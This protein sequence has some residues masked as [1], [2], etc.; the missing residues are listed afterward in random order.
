MTLD[1]QALLNRFPLVH[2]PDIART[3]IS[4]KGVIGFLLQQELIVLYKLAAQAPKGAQFLEIGSFYGLSSVITALAFKESGNQDARLHCVDLWGDYFGASIE[5]FQ[6]NCDRLEVN[7]FISAHRESSHDIGKRFAPKSLDLVFIDGDHSYEG[8]LSDLRAS[9]PLVK[10]GCRITGHDFA[11]Y[12]MPVVNAVK[13]F[14]NET[15]GANFIAPEP[16]S[17]IFTIVMP[18]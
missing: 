10:P 17:S 7:S 14:L 15:P 8:C 11:S 18:S 4:W 5:K 12:S 9:A 1:N 16:G 3:A 2:R 6:A 13:D